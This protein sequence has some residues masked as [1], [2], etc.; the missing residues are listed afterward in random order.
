MNEAT[1]TLGDDSVLRFYNL[2][3]LLV[4]SLSVLDSSKGSCKFLS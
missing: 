4:I 3:I 1:T 2:T